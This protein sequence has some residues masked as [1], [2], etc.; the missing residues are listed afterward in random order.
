MRITEGTLRRIIREELINNE[1]HVLNESLL[2][3]G[4]LQ[5]LSN[6][7]S[8]GA[9]IGLVMLALNGTASAKGFI[10]Q[11][12]DDIEKTESKE[13]KE[14]LEVEGIGNLQKVQDELVTKLRA[15]PFGGHNILSNY[16]NKFEKMG[17]TGNKIMKEV[18]SLFEKNPDLKKRY[19]LVFRAFEQMSS[20]QAMKSIGF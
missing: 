14:D 19:S 3:E 12:N 10:S 13:S 16:T 15:N 18:L 2:I 17:E 1:G 7:V 5:D 9:A 6:K 11:I 20:K 4:V 8:Q